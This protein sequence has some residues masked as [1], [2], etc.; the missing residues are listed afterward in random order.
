MFCSSIRHFPVHYMISKMILTILDKNKVIRICI[1]FIFNVIQIFQT[2]M[3]GGLVEDSLIVVN[4]KR[5]LFDT[6]RETTLSWVFL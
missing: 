1:N 5:D 6:S 3:E 4:Y 2:I